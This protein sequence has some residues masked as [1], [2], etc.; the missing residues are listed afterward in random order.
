VCACTLETSLKPTE[1]FSR[2]RAQTSS[3]YLVLER[4]REPVLSTSTRRGPQKPQ[5]SAFSSLVP[6]GILAAS[7]M[8]GRQV[9]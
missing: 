7:A 8:P 6:Y 9:R 4:M 3:A 2:A 5:A 1:T